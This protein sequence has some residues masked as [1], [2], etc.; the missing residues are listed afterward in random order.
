MGDRFNALA[1]SETEEKE[2]KLLGSN[3]GNAASDGD[4]MSSQAAER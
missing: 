4:V 2:E 3:D 1:L